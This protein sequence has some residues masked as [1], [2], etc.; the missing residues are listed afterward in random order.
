MTKEE[1]LAIEPK[2]YCPNDVNCYDDILHEVELVNKHPS[3]VWHDKSEE[4]KGDNWKILC[5]TDYNECWVD[6]SSNALFIYII[7]DM[8]MLIL[9]QLKC[10]HISM[11][12]YRKDTKYKKFK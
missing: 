9:K 12:C 5:L 7:H 6:S 4:P 3:D 10:G 8:N 11:T 1:Q 2:K